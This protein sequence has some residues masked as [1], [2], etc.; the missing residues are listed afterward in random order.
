MKILCLLL[1]AQAVEMKE[2]WDGHSVGSYGEVGPMQIQQICLNDYMKHN[3]KDH[4]DRTD[5]TDSY[6]VFYWYI[7]Y[8]GKRYTFEQLPA[9]WN[10]G[11]M[12]PY[13]SKA[14]RY[15]QDAMKNYEKLLKGH[16]HGICCESYVRSRTA[17]N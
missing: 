2:N 16:K 15:C 9:V 3:P 12:G 14:Q 7:K 4:I 5:R 1:L 10:G 8:Y 13:K 11:P 17:G 6:R